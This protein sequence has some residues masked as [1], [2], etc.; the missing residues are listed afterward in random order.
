MDEGYEIDLLAVGSGERSGDAI[1]VRYGTPGNYRVMIYDGGTRESGENL[2]RHVREHYGTNYVDF[3]VCS[4]PDADHASGLTTV[5]ENM[6]VGALWMH[7]PWMYSEAIRQYFKDG[8]ITDNSLT[9][10]LRGKLSAAYALE[11]LAATRGIPVHEPYQGAQIGAFHVMSPNK[12][13]YVH[14]L[15][16]DFAK[17]PDS[18]GA[19]SSAENAWVRTMYAASKEML[20]G[21]AESWGIETLREDVSTSAENESSAVLVGEIGERKILLTGDAG[22]EALGVT[23]SYAEARGISLPQTVKFI[24]VP[25][26]GSRNNVSPS[27]LDRLIGPRSYSPLSET[28]LTAFVSAAKES[29]THPRKAVVNGFLRRR[30][31]VIATKGQS[32]RHHFKMGPR[33]NWGAV[34]SLP[35]YQEVESWD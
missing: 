4:H 26:H 24:Q 34:Q 18:K 35:F 22:I 11:E 27:I 21:V 16:A 6:T 8:R 33:D 12:T 10:R 15:I 28:S 30:A 3:V 19:F 31:E 5:L 13:W 14:T 9:E 20:A 17:S 1:C 29:K 2:V 32:I 23:A 25:H 7:R